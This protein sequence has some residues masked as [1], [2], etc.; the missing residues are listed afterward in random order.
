MPSEALKQHVDRQPEAART[1]YLEIAI[2]A[3]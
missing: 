2:R 3:E 1:V